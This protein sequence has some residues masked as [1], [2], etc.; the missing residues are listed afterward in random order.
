LRAVAPVLRAPV[1]RVPV[2][3]VPVLRDAAVRRV[4]VERA[5]ELVL[6]E[7]DVERERDVVLRPLV[8]RAAVLR[9]VPL[10]VLPV[11]P[12]AVRRVPPVRVFL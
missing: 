5:D 10:L 4:P 7:P 9:R 12:A 2:L 8:D 6:L 3:R 1:L 11:R